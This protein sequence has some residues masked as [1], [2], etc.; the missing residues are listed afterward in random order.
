MSIRLTRRAA[1]FSSVAGAAALPSS[2]WAQ[3]AAAND[4]ASLA[5]QV[6]AYVKRV[7][8]GF[9][10]QPAVSVALVKDGQAVLTRGYG[11]RAIGGAAVDG[12]HPVRHRLEHQ[13]GDL[14]RPR[15]P[16]R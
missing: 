16:D 12:A 5:D 7:M 10:D 2:G 11:V 8:A 13:G 6:D 1:L 15:D 4:S 9:P 14:R 3:T